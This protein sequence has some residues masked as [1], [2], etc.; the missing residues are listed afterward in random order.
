MKPRLAPLTHSA[1]AKSVIEVGFIGHPQHSGDGMLARWQKS[2]LMASLKLNA[3]ILQ[4]ASIRFLI[5][6]SAA[7]I[8]PRCNIKWPSRAGCGASFVSYDPRPPEAGGCS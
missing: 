5:A 7:N 4:H 1:L 2:A 6:L 3:P 8:F